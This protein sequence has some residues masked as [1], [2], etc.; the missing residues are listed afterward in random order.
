MAIAT[1]G[2]IAGELTGDNGNLVVSFLALILLLATY[3]ALMARSS[4]AGDHLFA[5]AALSPAASGMATAVLFALPVTVLL[6]GLVYQHGF[7]GLIPLIGIPAGLLLMLCLV[8]P[9]LGRARAATLPELVGMRFGPLART[10][11]LLIAVLTTVGLLLGALSASTSLAARLFDRPIGEVALAAVALLLLLVLPGGMR[12]I[13][14]TGI[15]FYLLIAVALVGGLAIVSFA[16]LGN[17][18]PQL[19]YG[20]ALK[21]IAPAE[22]ALIEAGLVDFGVFKPF[23]REFLTVDSLNWALLSI[24]LMAGIAVLPPLVQATRAVRGPGEARR[25]IAW[26]L[27]FVILLLTAV[28]GLAAIA[29]LE[30]YKVVASQPA[31]SDLPDWMRRASAIDAMRIHGTSL[32]MV[33]D[34]ARAVGQGADSLGGLATYMAD[35]GHTQEQVWQRLDPSVQQAVLSAAR[36]MPAAAPGSES[37]RWSRFAEIVLPVAAQS[38]GNETGKPD[39]AA[40]SLDPQTLMLALPRAAGLPAILTAMTIAS[41]L[42]AALVLCAALIASISGMLVHDGGGTLRGYS[43]TDRDLVM[44]TRVLAIGITILAAGTVIFVPMT[45]DVVL[46]GSL[47]L[48]AAGLMPALLLGIWWPRANKWGWLAGVVV[49]LGVCAYYLVGTA[50]FSVTFYDMWS[51][52]SNAGPEALEDFEEAKALWL[53]SDGDQRAAAYADLA[54]RA[55]GGLWSPGLANWFGIAP[56]AAAVLAIPAALTTA[57]LVSLVTLRPGHEART[58]TARMHGWRIE[59]TPQQQ[60]AP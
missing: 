27:L 30:V 44:A 43:L 26:S 45:P 19:A 33:D 37:A 40:L 13:S 8:G 18:I 10:V 24:A 2:S 59:E 12:S 36:E 58:L 7:D 22:I 46:V 34:A 49:G 51:G 5:G 57:I 20:S 55:S 16:L 50:I 39:L 41:V 6:P 38:A 54:A 17:P 47:S 60:D 56:A 42:G 53:A 14:I 32:G 1:L 3:V 25:G 29:R 15:L 23:L 4:L 21:E 35:R 48:A 31:F 11:T 28:P 9:A 52:L